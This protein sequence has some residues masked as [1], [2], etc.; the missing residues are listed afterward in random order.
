MINKKLYYIYVYIEPQTNIPFYIGKGK[1]DRAYSHL[2]ESF[3]NTENKKKY[4][5]IKGLQNKNL[6]PLIKF[7]YFNISEEELAYDLERKLIKF[8][9]RR[10]LDLGGTLTNI[11]ID[12][13]PPNNK[14]KPSKLKGVLWT[15]KQKEK[16]KG[17]P[18]W[19]SGLKLPQFSKKNNSFYGKTHT[20]ES[21]DKMKAWAAENLHQPMLGKNHNNETKR[22]ISQNNRSAEPEIREKIRAASS[23]NYS[24][25][26]PEGEII[27]FTNLKKFCADNEMPVGALNHYFDRENKNKKY[28]K[29]NG[30]TLC[31]TNE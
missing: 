22:K 4:A 28:T 23:G 7:I 31:Q 9:G 6:D 30:W 2:K 10:D 21:K 27:K 20:K 11:C 16:L 3:S 5:Y 24:L 12:N 13:K 19:N 1:N 25:K 15:D 14:G 29:F 8:W 18:S 17:R 26:S